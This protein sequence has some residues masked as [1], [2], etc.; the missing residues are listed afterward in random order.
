MASLRKRLTG[1]FSIRRSSA[2][3]DGHAGAACVEG[4]VWSQG[5][6]QRVA[7]GTPIGHDHFADQVLDRVAAFRIEGRLDLARASLEADIAV[8]SH[9][10]LHAAHAA[11]LCDLG[12]LARAEAAYAKAL[13]LDPGNARTWLGYANAA[14]VRQD[15]HEAVGRAEMA[16]SLDRE[17]TDALVLLSH[18]LCQTGRL[19]VAEEVCHRA[20]AREPESGAALLT[21]A[22]IYLAQGDESAAAQLCE[23]CLRLEPGHGGAHEVLG[24]VSRAR[25]DIER[26]R[27][28]FAQARAA[29]RDSPTVRYNLATCELMLGNYGRGFDLFESRFDAFPRAYADSLAILIG[30]GPIA[31]WQGEDPR[32]R[33]L[34]LWSEQG[35]GDSIMMLRYIRVV[36]AVGAARIVLACPQTL[37]RLALEIGDIEVVDPIDLEAVRRCDLHCPLLS[38]P[39]CVGTTIDTIPLADGYLAAPNAEA[40]RWSDRLA[41]LDGLK[42]GISWAGSPTLREDVQR[43]VSQESLRPLFDLRGVRWISLQKRD[44]KSSPSALA[45]VTDWMDECHDFGSTAG[46]I[47]GLDLV[48]SVDTAVAHLA[49]A[50]GVPV[51]MLNRFGSEWRWG[52]TG[53]RSPWYS[54]L[55]QFR[56]SEQGNWRGVLASVEACLLEVTSGKR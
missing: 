22:T 39:G 45:S 47:A 54:S 48:V 56:Q 34:L 11:V 9:P 17:L 19:G 41:S 51:W 52:R 35:L 43:S 24:L 28:H 5:S 49:G 14:V 30:C 4:S 50:L 8:S 25:N 23:R 20:L 26:A 33:S 53:E 2:A 36:Q 3:D 38:L 37:H 44:G 12:D 29:G 15:F 21:L 40:R 7:R 16:V 27:E 32:G 10:R 13:E 1:G 6:S 18:S 55:R 42:V 31:R 46:L